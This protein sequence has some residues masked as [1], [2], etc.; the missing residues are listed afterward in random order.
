MAGIDRV[1]G[2]YEFG[3]S[4]NVTGT[5]Q[6]FFGGYQ[7]LFIK[8]A[9]TGIGADD[10]G[11]SGTAIT[12]GART[13]ALRVIQTLGTILM[14]DDSDGNNNVTVIVD[15]GSFNRGVGPTTN[16]EFGLLKDTLD[17]VTSITCTVTTAT[18][19]NSDGTITYA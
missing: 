4:T 6:S 18:A 19:L 10:T 5:K 11:G 12:E 2:Q 3:A 16:A 9:G 15:G 17:T 8:I 13:K 1:H 7:P 14:T